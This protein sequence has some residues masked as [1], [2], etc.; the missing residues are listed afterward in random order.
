[1]SKKPFSI[2]YLLKL[3][4]TYDF[5]TLIQAC[6]DGRVLFT[7]E[8]YDKIVLG[9]F[10]IILLKINNF[11]LICI[12]IDNYHK[13]DV[14]SKLLQIMYNDDTKQ[15]LDAYLARQTKEKINEYFKYHLNENF[16]YY[17]NEINNTN[18][19]LII[20][21]IKN[22][23]DA[24]MTYTEDDGTLFE[25]TNSIKLSKML[26]PYTNIDKDR[27][28]NIIMYKIICDFDLD[29]R[30]RK[31]VELEKKFTIQRYE[32]QYWSDKCTVRFDNEYRSDN[33]DNVIAFFDMIGIRYKKHGFP[34]DEMSNKFQSR[35]P[36]LWVLY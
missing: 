35:Y 27:L 1:M 32:C 21:L 9:H 16:K 10:A 23:A 19:K 17:L 15:T 20:Q 11:K 31:N 6:E 25:L 22:G 36:E 18:H 12:F 26:A 28:D 34:N 13:F 4:R 3:V 24:N 2:E 30:F 5:E 29:R 14:S 8:F 33:F 7:E